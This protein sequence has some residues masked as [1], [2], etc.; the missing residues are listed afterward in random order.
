MATARNH[1]PLALPLE[2][3]ES[4]IDYLHSDSRTLA[5]CGLVCKYWASL[6]RMHFFRTVTFTH[7]RQIFRFILK[8]QHLA[9]YVRRIRLEPARNTNKLESDLLSKNILSLLS[10]G[11]RTMETMEYRQ[12]ADQFLE[13]STPI[14]WDDF[15]DPDYDPWRASPEQLQEMDRNRTI[16][17]NF[18]G[19]K[20]DSL[21]IAGLTI[22]PESFAYPSCK[23]YLKSVRELSFFGGVYADPFFFEVI[24]LCRSC[25]NLK[26]LRLSSTRLFQS[27]NFHNGHMHGWVSEPKQIYL[28]EIIFDGPHS[29]SQAQVQLVRIVSERRTLKKIVILDLRSENA[30]YVDTLLGMFGEG[31]KKLVLDLGSLEVY[32]RSEGDDVKFFQALI[33][34]KYLRN[35]STLHLLISARDPPPSVSANKYAVTKQPIM[36]WRSAAIILSILS[37]ETQPSNVDLPLKIREIV[38]VIIPEPSDSYEHL[39]KKL[40]NCQWSMMTDSLNRFASAGSLETVRFSLGPVAITKAEEDA[41]WGSDKR[42][43]IDESLRPIGDGMRDRIRME[44]PFLSESGKFE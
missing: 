9:K 34:P 17:D 38:F 10:Q 35:L 30:Q 28:E 39:E 26:T 32:R 21:H 16:F 33:R 23:A 20:F 15:D 11:G 42:R 31:I 25:P 8:M 41:A 12:H 6:S 5:S 24:T 1:R 43:D 13:T 2:L 40:E 27:S 29:C 36:S 19:F 3:H 14:R 37:G 18:S 4:I 44:F 7:P 22:L